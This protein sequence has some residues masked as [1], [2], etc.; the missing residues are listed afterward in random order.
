MRVNRN[1]TNLKKNEEGDNKDDLKN[2]INI[3]SNN[4]NKIIDNNNEKN[5]DLAS[6]IPSFPYQKNN[7]TK[8]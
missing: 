7:Q 8:L 5:I 4:N 3:N 2:T 6:P 1:K